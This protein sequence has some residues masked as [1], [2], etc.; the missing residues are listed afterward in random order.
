VKN[1]IWK[2]KKL[3]NICRI[4]LRISSSALSPVVGINSGRLLVRF[5][6]RVMLMEVWIFVKGD[7]I[8]C[9]NCKKIFVDT[10]PYW[11]EYLIDICPFCRVQ[12][13]RHRNISKKERKKNE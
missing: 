8:E 10:R 5:M 11:Q 7:K 1:K 2:K 12:S 4:F 3:R 9:C 13:S 6:M